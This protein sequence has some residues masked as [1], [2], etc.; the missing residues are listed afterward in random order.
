MK[1]LS[2][3]VSFLQ[4]FAT[5]CD[6]QSQRCNNFLSYLELCSVT[7]LFRV[8]G[9]CLTKSGRKN[10]VTTVVPKILFFPRMSLMS[11]MLC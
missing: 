10:C 1:R 11:Y 4:H 7:D 8:R 3:S 9:I 2:L 5:M 6:Y